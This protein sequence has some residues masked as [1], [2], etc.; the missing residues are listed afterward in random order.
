MKVLYID[1]NCKNSST[2]Q[3]VY[4]LFSKCKEN[5][6]DAAIC[7][8][9]GPKIKE[10]GI[11]KFGL[12]IET[13]FHAFMTRITGY[14]G[15]FSFFSTRRLLRYI[16]KFN[17]D[18]V[19]IHELHAYFVNIK[20]LLKYLRKN[21]IKAIFTNH[22]DFLFTGKCGVAYPCTK[23]IKG[24]GACP[25]KSDYP[26]SAI[27]DKT[28]KMWEAKKLLF[29]RLPQ[30]NVVMTGPSKFI[31]NRLSNT[32]L[33]K[34]R[35]EVIPNFVDKS[36]RINSEFDQVCFKKDYNLP[37]DK[38]IVLMVA[39]NALSDLKGGYS[40]IK[41]ANEMK[42]TDLY[43][44]LIGANINNRPS[45]CLTLDSVSDKEIISK[46]YNIAYCSLI[47]SSYESFSLVAAESQCCGS[48]VLFF[49]VGGI[50]ETVVDDSSIPV[51]YDN[52]GKIKN[53]IVCNAFD[54]VDRVKLSSLAIQR[55]SLKSIS[56]NYFQL[57]KKLC[58]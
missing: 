39:S 33:S 29:E 45:N 12:D 16:R 51:E 10:K 55:F 11:Y 49:D 15:C 37:L 3:I 1:V 58:N 34:F 25:K 38:K 6:I 36:F 18:V 52:F 7:Y 57:Y 13:Y 26:K 5:G 46:F 43:F 27:F 53:A 28:S 42:D 35:R 50:K 9:R 21:N 47:L 4:S 32:F 19:H 40:F 24:C 30:S 8:G 23:Y 22:C 41:L 17:P 48:P 31:V 44:V 54:N 20:P 14:T 56:D 2:G